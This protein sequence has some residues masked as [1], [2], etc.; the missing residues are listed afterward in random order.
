MKSTILRRMRTQT[1]AALTGV[2]LLAAFPANAEE[3]TLRSNNGQSFELTGEFVSFEGGIYTINSPQMGMVNIRADNV[4]CIG[5][6]CPGAIVEE[7]PIVWDV[8]LWGSRRAFTEHVE[9]LAELV[10]QNTNGEFTLNISYGGLAPSRENLDGIA[11]GTFEMA[12]FCAGYHP[13]K[14]PSITVL[15]LPFLG[16]TSMEQE[17][18]VSQAVYNHPA[19]IADLARWNATL[20]MPTPQPQYNI[21]GVG[22]PP[23]TLAAFQNMT[24]RATGGAGDAINA[25]GAS[26][27][28]LPAPQVKDALSNGEINAVAFAPHA[29]M[30]FETVNNALWWTTNLNPGTANCPVVVNTD[31]LN[32]LPTPSR[33][34]LLSSVDEALDHFITNYEQSTMAAWDNTLRDRGIIEIT[35]DQGIL[36]AINSEVAAPTANEWV[37]TNTTLGLPAQELYD[38]VSDTLQD[39]Q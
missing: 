28:N 4:D 24:V 39:S 1:A 18:A 20:L 15:E 38:L 26:T 17:R 27:I 11:A 34:A 6:G 29:H 30:A 19:V 7:G 21:A 23:T 37:A 33:V 16:V 3:V 10:E 32:A 12:Q 35:I 9:K 8:S 22:T 13:E 5:D 31:A 2:A 25:L 14:N 36:S